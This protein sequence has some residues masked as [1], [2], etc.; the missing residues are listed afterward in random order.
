MRAGR[1]T[2]PTGVVLPAQF[3]GHGT[4]VPLHFNAARVAR[5]KIFRFTIFDFRIQITA[6]RIQK[7]PSFFFL[8][9][10][11]ESQ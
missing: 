4:A 1:F 11:F 9:P 6:L 7:P 10:A 8:F 2:T 5:R 3:I